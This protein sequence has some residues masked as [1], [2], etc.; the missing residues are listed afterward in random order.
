MVAIVILGQGS[1]DTARKIQAGL[2]DAVV[3]GL[4][5]R[6]QGADRVYPQFG[7]VLRDL[8]AQDIPILALCAAG[9]IIRTLAPVLHDKRAEPPVLAV[10][11]DGSAVVPLLGGLRGVNALARQVAG[12]LDTSAAI[13]TTGEI[14]FNVTLERPPSGY[15]VANPAAT[16]Q[17]MSDLLA[18]EG[19]RI[20]GEAPWL[21][22]SRLTH[23]P[24]GRLHLVITDQMQLPAPDQVVIHPQNVVVAATGDW[25]EI[26]A[27]LA[28]LNL[29]P[30]CVQWV[31]VPDHAGGL[32]ADFATRLVRGDLMAAE[33]AAQAVPQAVAWHDFGSIVIAQAITPQA[34]TPIGHPRGRLTVVGL[35]PGTPSLLAPAVKQSVAQADHIIGYFPYVEMAGPYRP[36]QIVHASDNRV[37]MDRSRHAFALAAEGHKVVVVSSGD[38]GVFAMATA[39][40]E[41][42]HQSD[43]PRW[44]GV[45]L[46][47]QPGISAAHAA[48]ALAGAPLGHDFCVM[49]LS[50]NLKPW[51]VVEAR[52][53]LATKADF[54]MAFYNP[55]SKARPWQLGKA[56]DIIRAGRD[57]AT[58]VILGWNVGRPGERLTVTTLGD[59]TPS[60]VDMRTVVIVGSSITQTFPR[61]G[62]GVWAYTPRWYGQAPVLS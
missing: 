21:T 39:V 44:H 18:G 29:S 37:E 8:Y 52:L 57:G 7:E 50:D 62:G 6:V 1:L 14:R 19:V 27:K 48:A 49:S 34:V 30:H 43:D 51:E 42:L 15:V 32:V 20:D 59:L 47:I 17:F 45:E 10:A 3:Y 24:Q 61:R 23:D 58:P 56:L 9:I 28:Q 40:I 55:I 46:V 25:A 12:I 4:D 36:D 11:E 22:Q 38:P 13:T 16:K 53:E 35:G 5:G 33:M 2:P 41:A 54:A 60:Q 26:P 31:A